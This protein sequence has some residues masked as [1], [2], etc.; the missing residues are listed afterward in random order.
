MTD[1]QDYCQ[2]GFKQ[3]REK[4]VVWVGITIFPSRHKEICQQMLICI[5]GKTMYKL[6]S[7]LQQLATTSLI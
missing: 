4:E 2:I 6:D 5:T 3:G 7:F 1:Y